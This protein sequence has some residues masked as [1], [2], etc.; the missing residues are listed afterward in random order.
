MTIS[1]YLG[2]FMKHRD[3]LRSNIT[4]VMLAKNLSS[5]SLMKQQ[6]LSGVSDMVNQNN[7]IV[8]SCLS[9][10]KISLAQRLGKDDVPSER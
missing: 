6:G 8:S 10:R 7:E 2:Q 3:S 5:P 9:V 1:I 4:K